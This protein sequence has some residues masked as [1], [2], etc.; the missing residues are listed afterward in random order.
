MSTVFPVVE[1]EVDLCVV[2]GGMS[3]YAAALAAANAGGQVAILHDRPM[4]GGNASSEVRMHICGADRHNHIKHM[5]ETG[6]LEELRL[7]NAFRNPEGSYG[8]WDTLLY[9]DMATHPNI[10][11]L[12]N[13][14]CLDARMEDGRIRSITGWQLQSE[15]LHTVRARWFADCSGDGILAP[16]SGAEFRSGREGREEYG[17]ANAP[18]AADSLTMGQTLAFS[19]RKCPRPVRFVPPAWALKF[20]SCDDLPYGLK[21]H[22]HDWFDGKIGYWW[23]ERGGENDTI[24]ENEAL[25]DELLR[26]VYGIWDHL[27]NHCPRKGELEY[28]TIDWIQMLPAKRESRRF[29]GEYVLTQNDIAACK[30]FPDNVAY[31]GW[32][33]DDHDPAGFYANRSGR[34]S[35]TFNECESGYGIPWRALYSRNVPNLLFAGRNASCTH[36]AMS[37]TGVMATCFIRGQAVGAG[38]GLMKERGL[39]KPSE[40]LAH[41]EDLQQRLLGDDCYIP[42]VP[43]RLGGLTSGAALTVSAGDPEPLRDGWARQIKDV[44]H[45]W[46][47][48]PGGWAEYNLPAPQRVESVYIALDSA[49]DKDTALS[50]WYCS[51]ARD[52]PAVL[53]KSFTVEVKEGGAWRTLVQEAENIRRHYNIPVGRE[54][55]GVRLRIGELWGAAQTTRVYAFCLR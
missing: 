45:A 7:R 55:E 24:H 19:V 42:G 10:T 41:I 6:L 46:E 18:E 4:L 9:E 3:G 31:G 44:T 11:L 2:G 27:K 14:S 40:V 32:T 54:V 26:I 22:G 20:E 28:Y 49:M 1:H 16:L 39:G 48:A 29:V 37:S 8:I 25:R 5:R 51:G 43:M 50:W 21:G 23:I 38:V 36:M 12:L 13:C 47:C 30:Q 34:P 15:T 52:M 35:T 53:P 17:E 33:M